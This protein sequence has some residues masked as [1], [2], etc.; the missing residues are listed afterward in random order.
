MSAELAVIERPNGKTY[1]AKKPPHA[2]PTGYDG[3]V[4][5]VTVMRTHAVEAARE[6]ALAELRR[7]DSAAE[8]VLG[9]PRTDWGHWRPDRYTDG[10]AWESHGNGTGTPAVHFDVE[11]W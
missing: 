7:Y 3:D 2:M 11:E 9:N 1:R 5:G 10:L 4:E 8:W 6:L